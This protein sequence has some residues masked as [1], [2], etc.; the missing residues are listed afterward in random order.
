VIFGVGLNKT[1]TT[2][3]GDAAEIL[4]LRRLGAGEEAN[5]LHRAWKK[6]DVD[7]L[8]QAAPNYDVLE[9]WPWPLA[10]REMAESF[11]DATF[12][13]TRRRSVDAWLV[14][15]AKQIESHGVH[16]WI[17]GIEKG[18]DPMVKLGPFYEK[19]LRD[20]RQY[21]AGTD[22]MIELCWEEG[23]GWPELCRFIGV[24]EPDVPFP[25]SNRAGSVRPTKAPWSVRK[26]R[27]FRRRVKWAVQD[28]LPQ[29]LPLP[30]MPEMPEMPQMPQRALHR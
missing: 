7:L 10:Y 24:A 16:G 2:T 4:G 22:R 25:H 19:H 15:Q 12:V 14:S 17:Y 20:V 13:L 27:K 23:D 3:L 11:P 28:K 29:P 21:F 9:D 30:R 8:R 1:G 26:A 6:G 5:R 18:E